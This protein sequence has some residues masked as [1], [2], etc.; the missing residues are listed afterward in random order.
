M[1]TS[2]SCARC[3][4]ALPQDAKFCAECGLKV[5]DDPTTVQAVPPHETTSAPVAFDVA[6]PRYFGLTPP[7]LLFAL[8]TATL[9]I[10]IA[11]AVLEHWV[12][13]IVVAVVS[14]A[15][16]GLFV[17][18]A[19]RKPD[20]AFA[21]GSAR[22]VDRLRQRT[23]WVFESVA[24]RSG[25]GRDVARLRHE[26]LEDAAERERLLRDLGA[27]VY[28]D[29]GV[30][31]EGVSERIGILDDEARRKEDEMQA[32]VRQAQ[33]RIQ[34][35]RL[36]V[37]PTLIEPPQPVPVPEP[38]PPPDEGTPPTPAPVPEPYPP[39]DEATPPQPP[40]IPEPGPEP[41]IPEPGPQRDG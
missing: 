26:L 7:M 37:Q 32:I 29:D 21:R 16:L 30:A 38:S 11:L 18:V 5:G 23:G 17:G 4:A 22:A 1:S 27:A 24:I 35:G 36:R 9:A 2:I 15:L 3:G 19:R 41:D 40:R 25:A 39:P 28:E 20:T 14:L 12:W 13:A 34:R 8:A 10:A 33:Q 31:R 6:R